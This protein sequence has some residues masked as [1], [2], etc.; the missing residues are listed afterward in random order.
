MNLTINTEQVAVPFNMESEPNLNQEHNVAE[1]PSSSLIND[2]PQARR[3][4]LVEI[5]RAGELS[6]DALTNSAMQCF[7]EDN[8]RHDTIV[9][10]YAFVEEIRKPHKKAEIA[11]L[12]CLQAYK[13]NPKFLV[14]NKE[15]QKLLPNVNIRK[16]KRLLQLFGVEALDLRDPKHSER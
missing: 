13:H 3:A 16:E 15:L 12:K 2:R 6:L 9:A 8:S 5:Q 14:D 4:N 10:L 1:P 11:A 7:P